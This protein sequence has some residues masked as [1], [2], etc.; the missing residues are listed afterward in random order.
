MDGDVF[1]LGWCPLGFSRP[2]S[3]VHFCA[4][5]DEAARLAAGLVRSDGGGRWRVYGTV[6]VPAG[7][8]SV[9]L[10]RGALLAKGVE[11]PPAASGAP[12]VRLSVGRPS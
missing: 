3:Q 12:G 2:R 7:A 8:G 5:L 4:D 9:K 6:S 1:Q 11:R 10:E